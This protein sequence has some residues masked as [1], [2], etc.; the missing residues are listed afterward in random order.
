MALLVFVAVVTIAGPTVGCAADFNP[1]STPALAGRQ[2][3]LAF[4]LH[5][6][7]VWGLAPTVSVRGEVAEAGPVALTVV[8]ASMNSNSY[9]CAWA[10]L[11]NGMIAYQSTLQTTVPA[12]V[13]GRALALYDVLWNSG[14]LVSLGLGG[15]LADAVSIQAVYLLGGVLLLAAG[16]VG[17]TTR[18]PSAAE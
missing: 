8:E 11:S 16:S 10:R 14:R 18:L 6:S 17:L 4:V 5:D 15:L 7:G 1:Q 3:A 2:V 9:A 12:E 13:R